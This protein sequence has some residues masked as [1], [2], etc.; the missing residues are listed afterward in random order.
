MKIAIR[1]TH[2][3]LTGAIKQYVE[4]KM[5]A[6]NKFDDSLQIAKV[7]L[8]ELTVKSTGAKFR[9]EAQIDAPSEIFRAESQHEDLYAAI[10]LLIPKLTVQ[11]EKAKD[12]GERKTREIK[13]K[14]KEGEL[15]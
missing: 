9:A 7:E 2:L 14:L 10:D 13:R 3:E 11:M 4:D 6:L 15:E 8:E 1:G 5:S 12:K